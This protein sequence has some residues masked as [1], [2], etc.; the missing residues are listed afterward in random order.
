MRGVIV[1]GA[2]AHTLDHGRLGRYV[3]LERLGVGGMGAVYLAYDPRLDRRVAIKVLRGD[4]ARS[5]V[6]DV[7]R[8]RLAQEA[9]TLA[10]LS[11]PN[12]VRVFDV[13]LVDDRMFIAMELLSGASVRRWIADVPRSVDAILVVFTAAA[14]GLGAAH[15]AGIVHRDFKADN[16]MVCDD[17]RTVVLDFGIARG[18]DVEPGTPEVADDSDPG[19]GQ[20]ARGQTQP[21]T[22]PGRAM[23]TPAYMAPEQHLGGVLDGRSDQY[24]WCVA[25]WEALAG[26]RP[27]GGRVTTLMQKK[28]AMR[29]DAPSAAAALPPWLL[30]VLRRGLAPRVEDRFASMAEIIAAVDAARPVRGRG[31]RLLVAAAVT[32]ILAVGAVVVIEGDTDGCVLDERRLDG[33]WSPERR[34]V[35]AGRFGDSPLPY[36]AGTW[37]RL[38]PRLDSYAQ[39][40]RESWR[41]VC[42]AAGKSDRASARELAC[43]E[44]QLQA[45]AARLDVLA[46]ATPETIEN[47]TRLVAD[48]PAP[49]RCSIAG[50]GPDQAVGDAATREQVAAV[51]GTL[52]GAEALEL[53]G[54]YADGLERTTAALEDATRIGDASLQA[55]VL[56]L[57]GRMH[58]ALGHYGESR[59]VLTDAAWTATASGRDEVAALAMIDLVVVV[60]RE[61]GDAEAG[62]AWA[63][64][65]EVAIVRAG[66]DEL[67]EAGLLNNLGLLQFR[68]GAFDEARRGDELAL[69]IRERLLGRE[70]PLVATSHNNLG[71]DLWMLG[72]YDEAEVQLREAIAIHE[73]IA[74]PDHPRLAASLDNL[75][76]LLAERGDHGQARPFI[77]RA[78]RIRERALAPDHPSLADT[79]INLGVLLITLDDD[80][81]AAALFERA[82]GVIERGVGADHPTMA[83]CLSNL[84]GIQHKRGQYDAAMASF[85]RAAE[86]YER[87]FG[88]DHVKVG[89]TLA[90]LGEVHRRRGELGLAE[91]ALV[92]AVDVVEGALGPEHPKLAFPVG[93]LGLTVLAGG[94]AERAARLL[95]RALVLGDAVEGVSGDRAALHFALARALVAA[96]A[97]VGPALVHADRA[98]ELAN[99]EDF[100]REIDQWRAGA[101]A[102]AW[103]G[104]GAG[105]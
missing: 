35:I 103:A 23:G 102:G 100:R 7:Y 77:E 93:R 32:G 91:A 90:N 24:S 31:R 72:R 98:R 25:L 19:S 47:A 40:W 80:D 15:D 68:Q 71:S 28:I 92:R 55:E 1:R 3:V 104:A 10:Q 84:G 16:V 82:R 51:R 54:R 18:T 56:L 59:T 5:Q 87:S 67:L 61:L 97:E 33:A 44:G 99:D 65:A 105:G 75:G 6:A 41:S 85:T 8:Q 63:D 48:L 9:K 22:N 20:A 30:P 36:A 94:D 49:E 58:K 52:A 96:G 83:T 17:G 45:L 11:H 34:A 70:H 69:G 53:A 13:G 81:G 101:G 62:H 50:S 76:A 95:E 29:F 12:I 46:T 57:V 37:S 88:P 14:A 86:I 43:L 89:L 21:L 64:N 42:G 26:S 38:E 73:A 39:R 2:T 27:F 66:G 79:L 74:G 4:R 60:G 78:L